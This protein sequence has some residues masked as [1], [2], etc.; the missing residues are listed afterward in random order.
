MVLDYCFYLDGTDLLPD[1]TAP[2]L[3]DYDSQLN[4]EFSEVRD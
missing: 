1:L 2:E 3:S 4:Y